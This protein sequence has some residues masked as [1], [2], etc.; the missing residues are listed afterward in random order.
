MKITVIAD[1]KLD[2]IVQ[3]DHIM[4]FHDSKLQD[5]CDEMI[6]GESGGIVP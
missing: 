4:K 3:Q 1:R 2:E 6:R 5:T